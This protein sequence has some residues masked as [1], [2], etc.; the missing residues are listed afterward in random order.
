M[1]R[2]RTHARAGGLLARAPRPSS[3]RRYVNSLITLRAQAYVLMYRSRRAPP[4]SADGIG[5]LL[6]S[7]PRPL[8]GYVCSGQGRQL[9]MRHTSSRRQ[10]GTWNAIFG[11]MTR[12][13]VVTNAGILV[14]TTQVSTDTARKGLVS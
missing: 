12:A 4:M 5:V 10:L 13:S 9:L 3:A 1:D 7:P 8:G 11:L 14:F 6:S 2:R